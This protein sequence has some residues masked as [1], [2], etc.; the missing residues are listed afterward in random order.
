M[1]EVKIKGATVIQMTPDADPFTGMQYTQVA[2]AIESNIPRPPAP[3]QQAM[4]FP[5]PRQVVWKHI[6]HVFVPATQWTNQ[7]QMWQKYDITIQ[8]NGELHVAPSSEG[9]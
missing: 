8:E 4:P 5:L 7:Y 9:T 2:F 3:A 6:L 1:P